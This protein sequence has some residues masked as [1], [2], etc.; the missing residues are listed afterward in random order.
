MYKRL[1]CLIFIILIV[2]TAGCRG[3][4]ASES[5][6]FESPSCETEKQAILD[7]YSDRFGS[8]AK[9]LVTADFLDWMESTFRSDSVLNLYD[10]LASGSYT[11]DTWHDVTGNT[12]KVLKDYYSGVLDTDSSSYRSDIKLIADGD[13]TTKIRVTGDLSLADNWHIMKAMDERGKGLSGVMEPQVISLLKDAD[14]TLTNNEFTLSTRGKPLNGK[15]YTFRGSPKRVRLYSEMGV[16]IVSLANNHA[17][18]YG[19]DAFK[20]TVEALK[21]EGVAYIGGGKNID[22]AKRP[23]YFISNGRKI[24]FTAATNAEKYKL[25]PEA[26]DTKSGVLR[27]YDPEKYLEVIREAA[28]QSDYVIAYVH[29][30]TE[31]SHDFSADQTELGKQLIDAGADIVIGAHAHILQGIGFYKGKPIDYNLGNF[32]FN[33]RTIDSGIFELSLEGSGNASYRF[34]PLL[35]SSCSVKT[36]DEAESRRILEFMT[37]H[38]ENVTFDFDGTFY[39]SH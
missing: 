18:D 35:Q 27:T 37:E 28:E 32:L 23:F 31:Y 4:V 33:A 39:E 10:D 20:D 26:T 36:V 16:D 11:D 9:E 15:Q 21:N 34:I 19:E 7:L 13:G 2:L 22:E 1:L 8:E 30:G 3:T 14:I 6:G 38:S 5:S 25:T 24:A 29:W 17:Y 12:L